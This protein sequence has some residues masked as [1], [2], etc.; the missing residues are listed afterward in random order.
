MIQ[1]RLWWEKVSSNLKSDA[2]IREVHFLTNAEHIVSFVADRKAR[3]V[4]FR[5]L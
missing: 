3:S 4:L 5:I 1:P 2:Y